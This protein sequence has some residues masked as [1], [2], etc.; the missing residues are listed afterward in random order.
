MK[1]TTASLSS[2]AVIISVLGVGDQGSSDL[3]DQGRQQED[4][5]LGLNSCY[6]YTHKSSKQYK[7]N[8]MHGMHAKHFTNRFNIFAPLIQSQI[9]P[10]IK[11][12]L[13]F[14]FM[15]PSIQHF[16][17]AWAQFNLLSLIQVGSY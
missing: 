14:I 13:F 10:F 4:Y 17:V 3:P 8:Q 7:M 9:F 2:C 1:I 11:G 16:T 5:K 15:H 12:S 6:I